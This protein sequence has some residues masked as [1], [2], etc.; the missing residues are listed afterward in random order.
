MY[1]LKPKA[2]HILRKGG[3]VEVDGK[4]YVIDGDGVVNVGD[5]YIAERNAGPVVL[6]AK[7]LDSRGWIIPTT[8]GFQLYADRSTSVIFDD[9]ECCK[10]RLAEDYDL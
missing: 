10:V 7:D 8:S 5:T 9:W 4:K 2:Q 6:V 1:T 3:V